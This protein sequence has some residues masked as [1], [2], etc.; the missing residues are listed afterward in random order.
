MNYRMTQYEFYELFF[1]DV[2]VKVFRTLGQTLQNQILVH[3]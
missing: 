3:L 2:S 1:W